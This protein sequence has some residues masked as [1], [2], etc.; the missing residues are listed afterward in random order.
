MLRCVLAVRRC[1][2]VS[3]ADVAV[4]P[5]CRARP[6][7]RASLPCRSPR[8]RDAMSGTD[9]AKHIPKALAQRFHTPFPL[10]TSST[11]RH[12]I[13]SN[14]PYFAQVNWP[15]SASNSRCGPAFLGPA[16]LRDGPTT[17]ERVLAA[18]SKFRGPVS[19]GAHGGQP[20]AAR[21][22]QPLGESTAHWPRSQLPIGLRSHLLIGLRSRA[23]AAYIPTPH[24][25]LRA[26]PRVY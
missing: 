19:I 1:S 8:T 4:L 6:L 13:N 2:A 20:R 3:G 22:G 15:I 24:G 9:I 18:V 21:A 12:T 14:Q 5:R 7:R 17:T 23:A 10:R 11:P 26:F 16:P 25:C